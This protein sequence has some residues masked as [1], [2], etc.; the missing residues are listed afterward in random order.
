MRR[1]QTWAA[2]A[3][4]IPPV[5]ACDALLE[6]DSPGRVPVEDL[7]APSLAQVLVNSVIADVECAWDNYVAAAA[8]HSDEWIASTANGNM[9]NWGLRDIQG[10]GQYES[11]GC[12][13]RYSP[14]SALHRARVQAA[15]QFSRLSSFAPEDVGDKE[16]FLA[17]VRAYQGWPLVALSEGF[18]ATPLDGSGP[19][20]TRDDV[21]ALALEVFDDAVARAESAGLADL[22]SLARVGRARALLAAGDYD[23]VIADT[24]VVSPDFA[25]VVT[26]DETPV[27]RTNAHAATI[28]GGPSLG[29]GEQTCDHRPGLQVPRLAGCAGPPR[30]RRH[31]GG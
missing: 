22:A 19:D 17:T 2:L 28:N 11:G 29:P 18:C 6:V 31:P 8:H 10:N 5:A 15:D 3:V 9:A 24:E 4:L 25:F 27:D 20:L 7:D 13:S 30:R 26:R 12:E 1:L 16:A 23:G 21:A 14:F